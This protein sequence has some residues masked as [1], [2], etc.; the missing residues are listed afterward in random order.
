VERTSKNS[1]LP[2]GDIE[3]KAKTVKILNASEIPPFILKT[4]PMEVM[5][6]G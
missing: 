2:T 3:V 1:K 5:N 6:F 4:I